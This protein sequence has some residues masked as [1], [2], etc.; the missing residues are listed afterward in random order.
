MKDRVVIMNFA[1]N[2]IVDDEAVL[3]AIQTGKVYA[4]VTDFPSNLLK[5]KDRVIALPHLGASTQEA[6]DNCATMVVREVMDYL[7]NGN[8]THSVN[9]P[10]VQM[11]RAEGT[12]RLAVANQNVP[13]MLGQISTDLANA[14]L[15]IIDMLNKSQGDVAYTLVDVDQA[16][17]EQLVDTL[18][19]IDGVLMVRTL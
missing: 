3:E 19:A 16:I 10:D 7:E 15:N 5:G 18:K 12:Y 13:N 14:G 2:G 4:Y 17:P 6:E 8:I 9:F 1:R 11:P